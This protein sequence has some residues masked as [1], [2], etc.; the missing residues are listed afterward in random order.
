MLQAM[1]P[2]GSS[3]PFGTPLSSHKGGFSPYNQ[4][5]GRRDRTLARKEVS[6]RQVTDIFHNHNNPR[7]IFHIFYP[8][9]RM[10][11]AHDP[12]WSALSGSRGDLIKV[13]AAKVH[14]QLTPLTI[15]SW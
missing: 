13:V 1:Q 8:E 10:I 2:G 5:P 6:I 7:D 11:K 3:P 12:M 15:S 14:L 9:G 4:V